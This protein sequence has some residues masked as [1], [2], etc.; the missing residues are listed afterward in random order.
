V[1]LYQQTFRGQVLADAAPACIR[2]QDGET[3]HAR[4]LRV[5]REHSCIVFPLASADACLIA[6]YAMLKCAVYI[7]ILILQ[8]NI[9]MYTSRLL[10]FS[11]Y[12]KEVFPPSVFLHSGEHPPST[13]IT[14]DDMI[15]N[16]ILYF[17]IIIY[18]YIYGHRLP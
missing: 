16:D 17:F 9:Y 11:H 10:E 8:I 12:Y 4:T 3:G 7:Y 15:N 6:A 1:N 2:G 5:A 14:H 13:T 18:I